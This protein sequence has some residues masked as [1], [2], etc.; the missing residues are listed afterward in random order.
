MSLLNKIQIDKYE[1]NQLFSYSK[2]EISNYS[3]GKFRIELWPA[4]KYKLCFL[5][6]IIV[7]FDEEISDD[8]CLVVQVNGRDVTSRKDYIYYNKVLPL[9]CENL[10]DIETNELL[11]NMVRNKDNVALKKVL[12]FPFRLGKNGWL[13]DIT[14]DE[15]RIGWG[16][17]NGPV[18]EGRRQG[19]IDNLTIG[20]YN[21]PVGKIGNIH[22]YLKVAD[23]N[24]KNID[25]LNYS[26]V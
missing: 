23:Q 4:N 13:I 17:G 14:E 8:L 26:H 22:V 3:H 7:V 5:E 12:F 10:Y 2:E 24:S 6:Y 9:E 25:K 1:I 21:L 19:Y 20:I 11:K 16:V 18:E 15:R